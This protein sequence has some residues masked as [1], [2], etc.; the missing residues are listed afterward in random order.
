MG[1]LIRID[2]NVADYIVG[3]IECDSPP[4]CCG[5]YSPIRVLS[6]VD[7][8]MGKLVRT[9]A[10][11]EGPREN[12]RLDILSLL[13]CRYMTEERFDLLR[14]ALTNDFRA[15]HAFESLNLLD[16]SSAERQIDLKSLKQILYELNSR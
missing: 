1:H 16:I 4:W 11:D 2:I 5:Y 6:P 8:I 7:I 9:Y 14:N 3:S 15:R 10:R 13:T 12:D